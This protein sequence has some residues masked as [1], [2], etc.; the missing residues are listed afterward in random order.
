MSDFEI[1]SISNSWKLGIRPDATGGAFSSLAFV[2]ELV[3]HGH[4]EGPW[5]V[6][7]ISFTPPGK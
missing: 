6:C 5:R 7:L 1:R 4:V 3:R 2:I